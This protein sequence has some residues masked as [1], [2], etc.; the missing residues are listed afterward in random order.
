MT[1]AAEVPDVAVPPT[2][3]SFGSATLQRRVVASLA[4]LA[5]IALWELYGRAQENNLFIPTVTQVLGSLWTMVRTSEFWESY[6]QTLGPFLYGWLAALITGIAFGLAMGRSRILRGLTAPYFAFL[7]ALPMSTMVPIVVIALGLGIT[8]RSMVVYLFAIID[9]ILTT[10]AGV[11]YVD[12]DL[13]AMARSFGMNRFGRFRRVIVPGSMPGIAAAIRVGTGRAVVGMVVMEL[14][15]VSLGVGKLISRYKDTFRSADLYAVV[16]SMAI[17]GL[18]M[19]AL[20]RR[21]EQRTLRW[22]EGETN[23]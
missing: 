8:S 18:V 9:V 5:G 13:L 11:R 21:L 17:F 7:N 3:R 14:L 12:D 19:L 4:L 1:T 15:L 6:G 16:V 20:V 2:P 22:R 23:S 10:A